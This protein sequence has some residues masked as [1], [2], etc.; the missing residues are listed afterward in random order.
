MNHSCDPNCLMFQRQVMGDDQIWIKTLQ[1]INPNEEV[2]I[3]Y[4]WTLEEL[5][6]ECF[7]GSVK[8]RY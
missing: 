8:C 1:E 4:G 2:T 7:C 6:G 3:D 5:G